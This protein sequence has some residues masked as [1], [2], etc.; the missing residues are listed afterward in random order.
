MQ[1]T[2]AS[3]KPTQTRPR[4]NRAKINRRNERKKI[5]RTD[6]RI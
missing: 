1:K 6:H 4:T 3:I 2:Q 5:A